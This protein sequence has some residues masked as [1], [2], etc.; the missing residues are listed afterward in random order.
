M[1]CS[2]ANVSTA[3]TK[4]RPIWP[5]TAGEAINSPRCCSI[6]YTKAPDV[7]RV[8]TYPFRYTRSTHS[9]ASDTCSRNNSG[10]VVMG[11]SSNLEDTAAILYHQVAS[12]HHALGGLR[13]SFISTTL[14][15]RSR[16]T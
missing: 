16:I 8:G 4:L 9:T 2:R 10:I 14:L 7:C 6:K 3:V 1:A 12:N 5:D 13:R 11:A 15:D